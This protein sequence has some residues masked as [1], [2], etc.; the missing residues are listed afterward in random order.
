DGAGKRGAKGE[1]GGGGKEADEKTWPP[2]VGRNEEVSERGCE[3]EAHRKCCQHRPRHASADFA[4]AIFR[5][6]G[7]RDWHFPAEPEVRDE[8]E[9][10]KGKHVPRSGYQSGEEREDSDC[11]GERRA[12][13][14]IVRDRAP[15]Q[16]TKERADQTDGRKQA[17]LRLIQ[18]ELARNRRQ[19]HAEQRKIASVE[20]HAKEA[21]RKQVAMPAGK[22]QALK[23]AHQLGRFAVFGLHERSPRRAS[24]FSR[25]TAAL[26]EVRGRAAIRS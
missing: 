25:T 23:T 21:E 3:R 12:A 13:A 1:R 14:D 16:R 22:R 15:E 7:Q 18:A 17:R 2:A 11:C 4:R 9:D 5:S 20:H 10:R 6:Q 8:A 24:F 19:R 26:C